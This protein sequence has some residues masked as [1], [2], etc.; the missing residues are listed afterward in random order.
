[1]PTHA[2]DVGVR[3]L[4]LK[5]NLGGEQNIFPFSQDYRAS[6]LVNWCHKIGEVH[7]KHGT[8]EIKCSSFY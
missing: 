1:M 3:M 4:P 7:K 2:F 5:E 8:L 6:S